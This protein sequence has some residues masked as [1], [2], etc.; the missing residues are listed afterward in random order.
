MPVNRGRGLGTGEG[1]RSDD[2]GPSWGVFGRS[3]PLSLSLL[4][5]FAF[6]LEKS[7]GPLAISLALDSNILMAHFHLFSS[8]F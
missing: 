4:L 5:F 2:Q 8:F 6:F 3:K 1:Y 7:K